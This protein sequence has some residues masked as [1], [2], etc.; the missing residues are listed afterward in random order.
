MQQSLISNYTWIGNQD[1]LTSGLITCNLMSLIML[2]FQY[3]LNATG[4]KFIVYIQ[5][6][7]TT[8]FSIKL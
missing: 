6:L 4:K 3:I 1:I 2:T 8:N 7:F 5:M